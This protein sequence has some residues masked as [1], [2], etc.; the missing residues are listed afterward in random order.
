M[1]LPEIAPDIL[2]AARAG[3]LVAIDAILV[4]IQPGVFNLAVRMLGHRE[5]ARDATQEILLKVVTHLGTLQDDARFGTWVFQI[6]RNHLLT[7][8]TRRRERPEVSLEQIG[9]RLE[10]GLALAGPGNAVLSPEDKAAARELA[11][12]CT[13][14][15]LMALDRP[16]RLSYVLDVVF[17]LVVPLGVV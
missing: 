10:Q 17:G 16:H 15:M 8:R 6:A 11:V 3:Q 5:D 9:A 2:A 7:A 1:R 14:G 13:Q 4:G 12:R